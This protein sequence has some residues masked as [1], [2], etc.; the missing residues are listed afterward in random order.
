MEIHDKAAVV[1]T[2]PI[3]KYLLEA[4]PEIAPSLNG[5]DFDLYGKPVCL[6]PVH[7]EKTPSFRW[8]EET[9]SCHCYGCG[10]G[11][12]IINLHRQLLRANEDVNVTYAEAVEYL[13]NRF[14]EGVETNLSQ[15]TPQSKASAL[16]F[17]QTVL[18]RASPKNYGLAE[19][20]Y[21]LI[22]LGKISGESAVEYFQARRQCSPL[23][24]SV[25]GENF[26]RW[27]F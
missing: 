13:Y 7:S 12:D 14:M 17:E 22:K 6:C 2:I 4:V 20:L 18:N 21:T 9:N 1:K 3:P 11:G 25:R 26:E 23:Y 19:D 5:I 8:Y 15:P 10:A 16:V 27:F 24:P